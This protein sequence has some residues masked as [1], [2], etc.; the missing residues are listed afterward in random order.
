MFNDIKKYYYILPYYFEIKEMRFE[1][2]VML[3]NV[4]FVL[5]KIWPKKLWCIL[6]NL[7]VNINGVLA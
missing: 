1:I 5:R 7:E 2:G 3:S 4:K 6:K